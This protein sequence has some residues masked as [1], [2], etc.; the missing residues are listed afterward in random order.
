MPLIFM[1]ILTIIIPTI[2]YVGKNIIQP[3]ETAEIEKQEDT[4]EEKISAASVKVEAGDSYTVPKDGKYR[5]ELHGGHSERYKYDDT[6]ISGNVGNRLTCYTD[7]SKGTNF[8]IVGLK[9]ES[10]NGRGSDGANRCFDNKFSRQKYCFGSVGA[11]G[12]YACQK[13]YYCTECDSVMGVG[14]WEKKN[15]A[16]CLWPTVYAGADNREGS[17]GPYRRCDN[18]GEMKLSYLW[19]YTQWRWIWRRTWDV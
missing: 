15:Y 9:G 6:W 7:I 14:S 4:N 11:P 12:T 3:T 5:I 16:S 1:L 18:C 8:R 17:S 10:G 2:I 13:T 19:Y